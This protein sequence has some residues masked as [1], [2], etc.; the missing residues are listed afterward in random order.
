MGEYEEQLNRLPENVRRHVEAVA[1]ET[2]IEPREAAVERVAAVWF[3]KRR[4]FAE[5]TDAVGMVGVDTLDKDDPR[6]VLLLTYS[7]SL[8]VLGPVSANADNG[9]DGGAGRSFEYASIKTRTDV[10]ELITDDGVRLTTEVAVDRPTSFQGTTIE[11]SSEILHI[12]TFPEGINEAEQRERLR[13]AAIFLTNG[14]VHVNRTLTLNER[15]QPDQFTLRSIIRYVADRNGVAQILARD[16]IEDYLSTVETGALLTRRVSL[17][18]IGHLTLGVRGA[19][20]ARMGRNPATGA[21]LLIPAKPETTVPKF[22]FSA[23]FKERVTRV[24][25]ERARD[26][27][28]D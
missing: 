20:K 19:Q 18:S 2:G 27:E 24:P 9:A 25:V 14:F 7:A 10:P 11:R 17:G 23:A 22:T 4:L 28:P 6:G 1:D 13:Q 8:I 3:E 26:H 21:E 5:Q 15:E 16:I 12:A